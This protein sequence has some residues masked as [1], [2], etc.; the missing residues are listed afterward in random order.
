MS[1]TCVSYTEGS[2]KIPSRCLNHAWEKG[3]KVPRTEQPNK[4]TTSWPVSK[5][6]FLV[7]MTVFLN[8]KNVR[9]L[10]SRLVY[11]Y[12]VFG[13]L[14]HEVMSLRLTSMCIT[15][16]F[17][18]VRTLGIGAVK[19]NG[20]NLSQIL[21]PGLGA[22]P[23][24][25]KWTEY[26][27]RLENQPSTASSGHACFMCALTDWDH[28]LDHSPDAMSARSPACSTLLSSSAT[29]HPYQCSCRIITL[30]AAQGTPPVPPCFSHSVIHIHTAYRMNRE[31]REQGK[32]LRPAPSAPRAL[33]FGEIPL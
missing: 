22:Q 31:G 32:Q 21:N 2:T 6:G 17:Q 3:S 16:H 13:I 4:H 20:C 29:V 10:R 30:H 33:M 25:Q 5:P 27:H 23:C 12:P 11:D 28:M 18:N 24:I 9:I 15:S 19:S 7:H 14:R 1:A 26:L 8:K